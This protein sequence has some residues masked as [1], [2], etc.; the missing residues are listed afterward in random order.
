[1]IDGSGAITP[2]QTLDVSQ[3]TVLGYQLG[4]LVFFNEDNNTVITNHYRQGL[5]QDASFRIC[6][7][8][9]SMWYNGNAPGNPRLELDT[10][11]K[12]SPISVVTLE[13]TNNGKDWAQIV[14]EVASAELAN[15]V[16]KYESQII[17]AFTLT[18]T[19]IAE[20]VAWRLTIHSSGTIA[21][22]L[23][24][25]TLA[26]ALVTNRVSGWIQFD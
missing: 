14:C 13:G 20:L 26:N 16:T 5:Y 18:G 11:V 1:M 23:R 7:N 2:N 10:F 3:K 24:Q 21:T 9:M 19:L 22:S 25:N 17:T 15:V 6:V 12:A 8:V 4:G